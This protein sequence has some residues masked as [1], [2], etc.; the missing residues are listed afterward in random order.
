LDQVQA[1]IFGDF[2]TALELLF[3]QFSLDYL[4]S[5]V[6]LFLRNRQQ[7][8]HLRNT[9]EQNLCHVCMFAYEPLFIESYAAE[10]QDVVDSI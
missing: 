6:M 2:T 7:K 4:K 1:W 3:F 9:I 5:Q 8:Q 10:N